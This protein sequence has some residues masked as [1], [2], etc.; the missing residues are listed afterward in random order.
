M[1]PVL[2]TWH[3]VVLLNPTHIPYTCTLPY[4][5]THTHT[6]THTYIHTHTHMNTHTDANT[7]KHRHT[8]TKIPPLKWRRGGTVWGEREH[9]HTH[10]NTYTHTHTHTSTHTHTHT[11]IN[12]HT[13]TDNTDVGKVAQR[14][15][16]REGVHKW[17][18]RCH[19]F[20]E[21]GHL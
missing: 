17:R 11:N 20:K 15:V 13:N 19:A 6:H 7:H 21:R 12:T 2:M 4:T 1:V 18:R 14:R 9:T 8:K 10:P 3:G 5:H 16:L